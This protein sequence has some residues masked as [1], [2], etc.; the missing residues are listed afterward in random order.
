[1]PSPS[2]LHP[3]GHTEPLPPFQS[4]EERSPYLLGSWKWFVLKPLQWNRHKKFRLP[5]RLPLGSE[6]RTG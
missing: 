4:V 3:P 6:L 1:M 5:Q 2:P